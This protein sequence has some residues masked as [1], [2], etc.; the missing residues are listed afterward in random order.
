MDKGYI[1]S[2]EN[3]SEENTLEYYKKNIQN[4]Q[5]QSNECPI[6]DEDGNCIVPGVYSDSDPIGGG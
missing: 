6:K 3:S 2:K 5:E 1:Q 4:G